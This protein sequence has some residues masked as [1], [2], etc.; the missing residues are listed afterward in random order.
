MNDS[1]V[2]SN[3]RDCFIELIHRKSDSG[4]WI[5]RRWKKSLLL[6]KRVSSDWFIDGEQALAF[7]QRMK[8]EHLAKPIPLGI[9]S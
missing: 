5:V 4:T 6:K 9:T 2:I 1:T 3:D 7:A 8:Q